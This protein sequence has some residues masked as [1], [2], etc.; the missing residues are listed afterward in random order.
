MEHKKLELDISVNSSHS[1]SYRGRW[2]LACS[3][4][5]IIAPSSTISQL[6][7]LYNAEVASSPGL[8][9][10]LFNVARRK[11]GRSQRAWYTTSHSTC[12]HFMN[13]GEVYCKHINCLHYRSVL[14]Y[15]G[16]Y[17][18]WLYCTTYT[19]YR[20]ISCIIS[21]KRYCPQ[22]VN[23]DLKRR[24]AYQQSWASIGYRSSDN[25]AKKDSYKQFV[26]HDRTSWS[27]E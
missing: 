11:S 7:L 2:T 17:N 24:W 23:A 22:I 20:T 4:L 10:Q 27:M 1:T 21:R 3:G 12:H 26:N 8:L 16:I 19:V 18:R 6:S 5:Q 25:W 9:S 14:Y 15:G 13:V